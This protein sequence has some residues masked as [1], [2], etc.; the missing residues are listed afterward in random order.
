MA[1]NHNLLTGQLKTDG[2]SR[3]GEVIRDEKPLPIHHSGSV[4]RHHTTKMP[5]IPKAKAKV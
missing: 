2:L 1:I 4:V 5:R 3:T